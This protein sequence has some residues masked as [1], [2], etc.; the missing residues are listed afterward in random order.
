MFS[1]QK[2]NDK[3]QALEFY[4]YQVLN[5][6]NGDIIGTKFCSLSNFLKAKN[7][8]NHT[9]IFDGKPF[10][11]SNKELFIEHLINIL[12]LSEKH[13]LYTIFLK[14]KNHFIT[15]RPN[16]L[17]I[18]K[19]NI[20]F[21]KYSIYNCLALYMSFNSK[22][23]RFE[24]IETNWGDYIIKRI[25]EDNEYYECAFKNC[26]KNLNNCFNDYKLV[27][28]FKYLFENNTFTKNFWK[29]Y[30]FLIFHP[31]MINDNINKLLTLTD[32]YQYGVKTSDCIFRYLNEQLNE[33]NINNIYKLFD[34]RF[35]SF[36]LNNTIDCKIISNSNNT[37]D[38]H[39]NQFVNYCRK[40]INK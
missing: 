32:D 15:S 1:L 21:T 7:K 28:N 27:I 11:I 5:Y 14:S 30:Q 38:M 22:Y 34:S 23:S 16:L 12:P 3:F 2:I 39:F 6:S 33:L 19:N 4:E 8:F 10:I 29:L 31:H 20:E 17:N 35:I 25:K 13:L 26:L 37:Y 40:K 9:L 24:K 18:F 36:I